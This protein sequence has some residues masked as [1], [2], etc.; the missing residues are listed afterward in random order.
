MDYMQANL[1]PAI[2]MGVVFGMLT[3]WA[4][5][6]MFRLT[7][8]VGLRAATWFVGKAQETRAKLERTRALERKQAEG[9]S[10]P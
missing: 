2:Y 1:F 5:R 9:A 6:F 8:Q 4:I 10:A 3:A 7:Y